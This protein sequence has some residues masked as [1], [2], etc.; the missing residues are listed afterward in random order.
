MCIQW[1][2]K[3]Y[4]EQ[5]HAIYSATELKKKIEK[6]T[7]VV[8]SLQN[9]CNYLNK[10]P[11]MIRLHTVEIICSAL[12]CKLSDFCAITPDGVKKK[13]HE[14]LSYKNTPL[15]KRGVIQFPNPKDY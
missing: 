2:L 11:V 12:N 14:K 4:L 1:K 13:N 3:K 8:I 15:A 9:L 10:T 6:D 5:K 7:G